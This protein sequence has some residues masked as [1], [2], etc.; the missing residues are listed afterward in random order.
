MGAPSTSV[1]NST[2]V[3][4]P[5]FCPLNFGSAE[6]P[7]ETPAPP[8]DFSLSG[9]SAIRVCGHRRPSVI[10]GSECILAGQ[11]VE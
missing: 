7:V 3:T 10:L 11:P 4:L 8:G 1:L 2:K 6:T 5:A 9:T